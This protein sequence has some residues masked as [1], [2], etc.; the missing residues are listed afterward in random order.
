MTSACNAAGCRVLAAVTEAY[1]NA[2]AANVPVLPLAGN[3]TIELLKE[4]LVDLNEAPLAE[5]LEETNPIAEVA[6]VDLA[7]APEPTW[8]RRPIDDLK[9]SKVNLHRRCLDLFSELTEARARIND[10]ERELSVM[11]YVV[12]DASKSSEEH[13]SSGSAI[14][15]EQCTLC[16]TEVGA[17]V[18]SVELAY[19]S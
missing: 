3:H 14:D 13:R 11:K 9:R 18:A 15:L 12:K 19:V 2:S 4:R 16:A 1:A 17:Q 10:L 5:A 6:K 8:L 7:Q